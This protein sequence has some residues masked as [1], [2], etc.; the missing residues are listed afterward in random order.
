M[1]VAKPRPAFQGQEIETPGQPCRAL[2][3]RRSRFREAEAASLGGPCRPAS[4]F[5][6]F[7][8]FLLAGF[9]AA[10]LAGFF[11]T[12]FLAFF[13]ATTR[14]PN[15]R[16]GVSLVA[17][18]AGADVRQVPRHRNTTTNLPT[19]CH[20]CN[21]RR[22]KSSFVSFLCSKPAPSQG[23]SVSNYYD[24]NNFQKLCKYN[25]SQRAKNFSATRRNRR[26]A[27]GGG[28]CGDRFFHLSPSDA[29][30]HEAMRRRL[31]SS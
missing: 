7:L 6:A 18:R 25:S 17:M 4:Y 20:R 29:H 1:A 11:A 21:A 28:A 14:P 16:T 2:L 23:A 8:A 3:S 15:K 27:Y 30:H 12:F 19:S 31:R 9:F 5:L 22:N 24:R 13:L 26:R 10:F